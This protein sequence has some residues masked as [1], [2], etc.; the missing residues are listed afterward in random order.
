[1]PTN[2]PARRKGKPDQLDRFRG[3]LIRWRDNTITGIV[4]NHC[5]TSLVS[6]LFFRLT[7]EGLRVLLPRGPLLQIIELIDGAVIT[8]IFLLLGWRII[9]E[10]WNRAPRLRGKVNG[11]N[12]LVALAL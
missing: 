2:Q 7:Y 6:A 8:V 3:T 11:T 4:F 12:L 10:T 5:A 1:M 9:V